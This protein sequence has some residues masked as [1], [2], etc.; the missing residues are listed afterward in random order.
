M[1]KLLK[2]KKAV[3]KIIGVLAIIIVFIVTGSIYYSYT[4]AYVG[5][6]KTTFQTQM[7]KLLLEFVDI[8][9]THIIA[10][11]RNNGIM[12]VKIIDA[13]VEG[14]SNILLKGVLIAGKSIGTTYLIGMYSKGVSYAVKLMFS[15]GTSI[16]FS[17]MY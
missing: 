10:S 6:M 4:V 14:V 5:N 3:S 17:V 16:T 8:N 7:E 12:D 11:V 2:T 9:S 1:K 13:Y 15:L